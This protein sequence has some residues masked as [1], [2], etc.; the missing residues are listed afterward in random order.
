MLHKN[1]FILLAA[2]LFF[3]LNVYSQDKIVKI[4]G[5][6]FTAN[7]IAIDGNIIRFKYPNED[8]QNS[9]Y[10]NAVRKI[11]FKSGRV[12]NFSDLSIVNGLEDWE[13]VRITTIADD[14]NGMIPLRDI[15]SKAT[16]TTVFS[17]VAQV[18]N[19]AIR[20]LKQKAAM[21]G[22]SVIFIQNQTVEGVKAINKARTTITGV[23]YVTRKISMETMRQYIT[24]KK[25]NLSSE[26]VMS[27]NALSGFKQTSS[28]EFTK[29]GKLM[30]NNND[31]GSY[32]ISKNGEL[33]ISYTFGG[34]KTFYVVKCS[35]NMLVMTEVFENK[36]ISY[37]FKL[38]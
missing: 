4:N 20:K 18:E 26:A 22:A 12:Q 5:D 6:S 32:S 16:G 36:T 34:T 38:Q 29:E 24:G 15:D 9:E 21:M 19:R 10:K 25:F 33:Q 27:N 28:F 37:S 30:I 31:A 13:K 23:A 14:V 17:N 35:D 1:L 11:I 8:L 7:V 3:G 2:S